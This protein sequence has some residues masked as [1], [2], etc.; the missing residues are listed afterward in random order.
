MTRS[1]PDPSPAT[2]PPARHRNWQ[3]WMPLLGVVLFGAALWALQREIS[4]FRYSDFLDYIRD[5]SHW[6]LSLALAAAFGAYA[7]LVAYDW[8][9]IRYVGRRLSVWRTAFAAFVGYAFSM[10]IGHAVVSGGAVRMRLYPGWGFNAGEVSRVI[11]FNAV[12][13]V[14]GQCLVMGLLFTTV[15]LDL[16][17]NLQQLPDSVIP[18]VGVASLAVVAAFVALV[19]F[20]KAPLRFRNWQFSLPRWTVA[21]P[22]IAVAALDWSL[23]GL[24]LYALMPTVEGLSLAHFLGIFMLAQVLG[25]A[26]MVPGGVGVFETVIVHLLPDNAPS[27][28]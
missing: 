7:I 28:Q 8:L 3:R 14:I 25:I 9:A 22:A 26:S 27:E 10:N 13:T 23:F 19:F 21:L 6:H 18:A 11:G 20:R 5:L 12:I 15:G 2:R 4:R 17:E 24:V 16:P 1:A